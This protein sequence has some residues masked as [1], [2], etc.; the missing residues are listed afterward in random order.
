MEVSA[1]ETAAMHATLVLPAGPSASQRRSLQFRIPRSLLLGLVVALIL[2]LAP[3]WAQ[4]PGKA[5]EEGPR[6]PVSALERDFSITEGNQ[7]NWFT[8][9]GNASS[10]TLVTNAADPRILVT[11]PDENCG[12]GIWFD[13]RE[14][15]NR[16]LA[17][18]ALA[19]PRS[20]AGHEATTAGEKTTLE[21]A[22]GGS[23]PVQGVTAR[24]TAGQPEMVATEYVL[25]SVRVMRAQARE[26]SQ[27]GPDAYRRTRETF[28][29]SHPHLPAGWVREA[30]RVA[31]R[32]DG[33]PSLVIERA[34]L[35]GG[36]YLLELTF[37]RGT[38]LTRQD[39]AIRIRSGDGRAL[40]FDLQSSVPFA[41]MHRSSP[42][43]LFR[44]A[45][46]EMLRL[47]TSESERP[48][49]GRRRKADCALFF[50]GL[51]DL[52]FLSRREKYM[53]GAWRFMT[54]FGRD[55]MISLMLLQDVLSAKAR[56]EGIESVLARLAP[57][58]DV[59][60]EEDIGPFAEIR[61]IEM[62]DVASVTDPEAL[63]KGLMAPVHDYKMVDD[64]FLLPIL[65]ARH[66]ADGSR[67]LA[68]RKALLAR[69][70]NLE[71]LLTNWDLVLRRALP[72]LRSGSPTDFVR[73]GPGMRVGNWRDS[74]VG[75]GGGVFPG[76]VNADL[77]P[78]ALAAI[79]R[80]IS[81]GTIG[82]AEIRAVAA[83]KNLTS[84][85]EA[86]AV[87]PVERAWA[88]SRGR[89]EVELPCQQVRTRLSRFLG[90]PSATGLAGVTPEER[91]WCLAL[92]F[93]DGTTLEDFLRGPNVPAEIRAPLRFT[94]LS[95]DDQGR[96]VEVMNSDFVF[97]LF[98]G[99]PTPTE[100]GE[101]VRLVELPYPLGL[102]TPVGPVVAN[103]ATSKEP[104]LWK[105]LGRDA[106]H[107]AVM[108]SWQ[109]SM[110]Q[111]GML[112]Q[113]QRFHDDPSQAALAS[114]LRRAVAAVDTARRRAGALA[115]SELWT[116]EVR[117]GRVSAVAFGQ[118]A[119]SETE[120]NAVQLWS[121]IFPSVLMEAH[122]RQ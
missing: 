48:G 19:A 94:A 33:R 92:R 65:A 41:A 38:S 67:P 14:A 58:G 62:G 90:Y 75:L 25:D 21:G 49:A 74:G 100:V 11:Y 40:E 44:P 16:G 36:R 59:A 73:I 116:W 66:L 70:D 76:D 60:H 15:A 26:G 64:D 53:A 108:W 9:R 83:R 57:D 112:R 86:L 104:R 31:Q 30:W 105:E 3:T 50:A 96:A 69:G 89:L 34:E 98:L 82:E 23:L 107:G 42:R 84:L 29:A 101:M 32:A 24:F 55:T 37:A 88:R 4:G 120:S 45:V 22:G 46:L 110:L 115:S 114:R 10:H 111:M 7:V 39:H 6:D 99:N 52:L 119:G 35:N 72:L 47:L 79:R 121:T 28:R 63:A 1:V 17:I 109:G 118:R 103:A 77:V 68:D 61:H 93:A 51:R 91:A 2:G 122:A 106:Y 95:L 113:W 43:E 12:T 102:M 117:G 54:Y 71:R 27:V 18:R 78:E 20:V 97:R 8:S 87:V 85:P 80:T 5:R 81:S 56:E 13:P